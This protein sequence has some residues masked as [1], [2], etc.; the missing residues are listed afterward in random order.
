MPILR[1]ALLYCVAFPLL[2]QLSIPNEWLSVSGNAEVKVV[3][4]R[5][6]IN[7]G[8]ES[9]NPSLTLAKSAND[10]AIAAILTVTRKEQIS[11]EDVQTD[12]IEI[13]PVYQDRNS[14]ENRQ[15]YRID[16][17]RVNK[18]MV[19]TLKDISRFERLLTAVVEAG[20]NQVHGVEFQTSELRKYRDQ[21][22]EMAVKAAVEK[23][24][25]MAKAAG[26]RVGK[27]ASI[28]AFQDG[29]SVFRRQNLNMSQNVSFSPQGGESGTTTSAGRISVSATVE[30]RFPLLPQ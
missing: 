5:V 23:A 24:A 9:R 10:S 19:I 6:V 25:A 20:A 29:G 30:L 1:F 28:S 26:L 12:F 2:A 17:Y 18:S 15:S 14:A 27:A 8:V 7:V 22:R 3:P 16:Y 11:A 4:D 13:E 21:A